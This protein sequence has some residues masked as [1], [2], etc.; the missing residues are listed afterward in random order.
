MVYSLVA[1]QPVD[2][3][4][5]SSLSLIGSRHE[6]SNGLK[7]NSVRCPELTRLPKGRL[8]KANW[9]FFPLKV[10]FSR[11]KSAAK[12][13]CVKTFSG[14]VVRH[15]LHGLCNRAQMVAGDQS[16]PPPSKTTFAYLYSLVYSSIVSRKT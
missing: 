12:F 10:Y 16:D 3:A 7:M 13:L 4:K 5:K 11:R 14:K 9:P 8:K 1:A 15:S 2:L 6:L